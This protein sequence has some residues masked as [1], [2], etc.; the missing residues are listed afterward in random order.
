M[1]RVAD[2]ARVVVLKAT[3]LLAERLRPIIS[4]RLAPLLGGSSWMELLAE[5]DAMSGNPRAEILAHDLRSQLRMLSEKLGSLKFPFDDEKHTVSTIASDL[6]SVQHSLVSNSPFSWLEVARATDLSVRLLEAL[7]DHAGASQAVEYRR[8]AISEHS[9][10]E[11]YSSAAEQKPSTTA[12]PPHRSP[13]PV[14]VP[15]SA[16]ARQKLHELSGSTEARTPYV[17]WH[18]EQ[19][20]DSSVLDSLGKRKSAAQVRTLAGEIIDH[21][22]PIEV[23]RLCREVIRAF[24]VRRVSRDRIRKVRQTILRSEVHLDDDGF[25]WPSAGE[26]AAWSAFRYDPPGTARAFEEISVKEIGNALKVVRRENPDA[27]EHVQRQ[28]VLAIFG[29]ERQTPGVKLR[30]DRAWF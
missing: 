13:T 26:R 10:E 1:S 29:R 21:E 25:V 28:K 4:A 5:L 22:W 18:G 30:L 27:Q 9:R 17:P 6:R 2:T 11:G 16:P 15:V 20:G 19:A 14:E 12:A 24:G 23:D 7:G 8:Y 3:D